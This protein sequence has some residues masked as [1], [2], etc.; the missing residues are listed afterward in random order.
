MTE[1]PSAARVILTHYTKCIKALLNILT[2]GFAWV[3]NRRN[4][5]PLLVPEHDFSRREP[6]QFGMISFTELTPEHADRHRLEFGRFGVVVSGE[7]ASANRAERVVYVESV[8]PA[9]DAWRSVFAMGYRDATARIRYPDDAA[10]LMSFENKAMAG[11]VA[12]SALWA[13][14]LQLYEY[15]E[16]AEHADQREWRIVH[17]YPYYSISASKDEAIRQVSPPQGWAH[18]NVLRLLPRDV[19]KLVCPRSEYQSV[20]NALPDGFANVDVL[21]TEG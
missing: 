20:R 10:W 15:M 7:W 17:P 3:A 19:K 2:S 21:Q 9:L 8:G 14:L 11:A 13:A 18:L 12:G 6:Q 16:S 1:S 5:M 4:L